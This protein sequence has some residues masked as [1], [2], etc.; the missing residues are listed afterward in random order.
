MIDFP[1]FF[2]P[3]SVIAP[4]IDCWGKADGRRFQLLVPDGWYRVNFAGI[5]V[6]YEPADDIEILQRLQGFPVVRG[7]TIADS[8][9]PLNFDSAKFNY[10]LTETSLVMFIRSELWD[11]VRTSRYEDGRLY[12]LDIDYGFDRV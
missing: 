2:K 12:Y 11:V 4:V 8:I 6:T 7:Y 9:V 3:K 1:R 10:G 5:T